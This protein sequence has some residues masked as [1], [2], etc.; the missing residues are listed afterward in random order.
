MGGRPAGFT[1]HRQAAMADIGAQR[2]D[3]LWGWDALLVDDGTFADVVVAFD[4]EQVRLDA[5]S[6]ATSL[7]ITFVEVQKITMWDDHGND[8]PDDQISDAVRQQV[9]QAA[10][11]AFE[12][13]KD[14]ITEVLNHPIP[15]KA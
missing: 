7:Q 10:Q 5:D 3:G 2:G 11:E 13:H 8:L 15:P 4:A 9:I 1:V 14:A 12:M 6:R